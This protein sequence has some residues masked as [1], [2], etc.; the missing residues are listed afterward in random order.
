MGRQCESSVSIWQSGETVHHL[1]HA[2]GGMHCIQAA[3]RAEAF[4][5]GGLR[6]LGV[7]AVQ[8]RVR[9]RSAEGLHPRCAT[10]D[11]AVR[12]RSAFP[13]RAIPTCAAPPWAGPMPG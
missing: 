7:D 13:R 2:S 4:N 1:I 5:R 12:S 3:R 10:V 11:N 8:G 6:V 9:A